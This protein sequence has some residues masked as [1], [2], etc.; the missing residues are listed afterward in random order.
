MT[1]K[2]A[3]YFAA[4]MARGITIT[5]SFPPPPARG[6]APAGIQFLRTEQI[7]LGPAEACARAGGAGPEYG[8]ERR[9]SQAAFYSGSAGLVSRATSSKIAMMATSA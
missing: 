2:K 6:Q 4:T 8:D 3:P 5:R 1:E 7:A 9:I